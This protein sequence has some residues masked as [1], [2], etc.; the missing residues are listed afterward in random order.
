M[1]QILNTILISTYTQN[2]LKHRVLILKTYL[3]SQLFGNEKPQESLTQT[4]L[5]W[6]KSLPRTFY[7]Q[8]NKDNVYQILTDLE[9][10][11][12]KL[13]PLIIYLPFEN[14][15][16]IEQ[17]IGSFVRKTFNQNL[18]LDLRLNPALIAGC[19]IAW[20]GVLRDYSL[21]SKIEEKK[22]KIFESFKKFLR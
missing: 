9:A 6:L 5:N 18:T 3:L 20:K 10:D 14:S 8:F 22:S 15:E 2:T 21:K 16:Q 13:T 17:S 12:N 19:T 7:Q 1:D 11:I 4:D